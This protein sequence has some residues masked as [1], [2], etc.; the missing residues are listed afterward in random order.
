MKM[1]QGNLRRII[2]IGMT[3]LLLLQMAYQVMGEAAHE[4]LGMTMT[5]TVIV[6]QI[7]NRRWYGAML[8]GRYTAY[9][10]V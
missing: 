1:R 8:K 3:V 4:W 5:A 7:L 2:D 6:H 9:R 10:V